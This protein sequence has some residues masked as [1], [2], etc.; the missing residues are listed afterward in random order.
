MILHKVRMAQWFGATFITRDS[1]KGGRNDIIL[2]SV[3]GLAKHVY[4]KKASV[5]MR[6][7]LMEGGSG[8]CQLLFA[9][10]EAMVPV[11]SK[12]PSPTP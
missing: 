5:N 6:S 11:A 10:Q 8:W 7:L 4:K 3:E 2:C 9:A 12:C 1:D